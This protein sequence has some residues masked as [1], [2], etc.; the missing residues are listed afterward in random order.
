MSKKIKTIFLDIEEIKLNENN[1]RFI[2]DEKLEK[3]IKSVKEF[4]QMLEIRPIVVNKEKM[5]LGGNMRYR[6]CVEAGMQ[7]LPVIIA[8][9]FTDE[10]ELEFLIKDNISGGEW[11]IQIL[12][13]Q[14]DPNQL[15]I[16]GLD[17]EINAMEPINLDEFFN[18]DDQDQAEPTNKIILEY[19]EEEHEKVLNALAEI[20]GTPEQAIWKL[21]EL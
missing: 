4:P 16:W 10:Q 18:E 6:A 12:Q 20:G 15:E 21:L 3:L 7:K 1:P 5:I 17:Q 9:E 8:D 14:F 2:R 19:T 11:D 13:D